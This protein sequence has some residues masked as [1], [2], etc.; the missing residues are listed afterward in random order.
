MGLFGFGKKKQPPLDEGER[1][2]RQALS[3]G[4]MRQKRA[5]ERLGTVR[6]RVRAYREGGMAALRPENGDAGCPAGNRKQGGAEEME[7]A[8]QRIEQLRQELVPHR[9]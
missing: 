6:N 9:R 1:L 8:E 4:G 7:R 3:A 5:A 2:Y